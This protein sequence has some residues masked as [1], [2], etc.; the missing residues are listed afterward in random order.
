M[1]LF[2]SNFNSEGKEIA[3]LLMLKAFLNDGISS[4]AQASLALI[5]Q[6]LVLSQKSALPKA[7]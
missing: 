5:R 7:L 2:L 3:A 1:G 4:R 6:S